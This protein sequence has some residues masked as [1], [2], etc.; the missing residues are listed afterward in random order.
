VHHSSPEHCWA[1]PSVVPN[2]QTAVGGAAGSD[3]HTAVGIGDV[4]G[5]G[6]AGGTSHGS[7]DRVVP[8][9]S[10]ENPVVNRHKGE[11]CF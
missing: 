10:V 8:G 3:C 7:T 1:L 11:C 5:S 6:S 9:F 2:C 4:A